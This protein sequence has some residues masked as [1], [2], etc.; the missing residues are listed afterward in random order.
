MTN[1]FALHASPFRVTLLA[2]GGTIEKTYDPH[3]GQLTL[4]V[5]VLETLLDTLDMPDVVVR[6]E[7]VMAKDSLDMTEADRSAIVQAAGVALAA[8][9]TDAVLITHGT[10]TL[11]DTAAALV[12]ALEAPAVPVVLTG[13]MRPYRVAASDAGQ[14]VAQAL[15]AARLLPAGVYAVLH[16]RVVAG[17]QIVKDYERLT[18]RPRD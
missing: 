7:R 3:S 6:V 1:P 4:A 2:T 10:D 8:G 5:P 9:E 11:A 12:A 18:I 17:D 16:G 13:A 15:M 14:N